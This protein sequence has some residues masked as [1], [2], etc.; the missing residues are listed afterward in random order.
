MKIEGFVTGEFHELKKGVAKKT[1]NEYRVLCLRVPE[2]FEKHELFISND[3]T[4][5]ED[6]KSG[7][8]VKIGLRV[9]SWSGRSDIR[10]KTVEK[11]S[12]KS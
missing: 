6:L 5:P 12:K 11:D 7:D 1:G 2:D 9:E 3:V 4:V 10:I 8:V